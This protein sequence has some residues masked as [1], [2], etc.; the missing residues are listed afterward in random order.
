[1]RGV[2]PSEDGN[3]HSSDA[4]MF[5]QLEEKHKVKIINC[6]MPTFTSERVLMY[7]TSMIDRIEKPD[8]AFI[9]CGGNDCDYNWKEIKDGYGKIQ[10]KHRVS[11]LDFAINYEKL[12]KLFI[13]RDIKPI[14]CLAP[15]IPT[16]VYLDDLKK[17]GVSEEILKPFYEGP[18]E[19]KAEYDGYKAEMLKLA[20]KY[21]C[22]VLDMQPAFE[23]LDDLAS[24]YSADGMHPN[25]AGY[26]LMH[27][28]FDVFLEKNKLLA[29]L[30]K[31]NK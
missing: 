29:E 31:A 21:N 22:L 18:E 20:D 13:E 26:K 8:F 27:D 23:E 4:L 7:A 1:M 9:E 19:M 30:A 25:E 6:A 16:H 2:M 24:V 14:V 28:S 15:P 11:L 17:K 3:Y 12:I 5:S 10:D